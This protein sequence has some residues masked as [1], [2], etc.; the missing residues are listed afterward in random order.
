MIVTVI[1]PVLG[2]VV[3]AEGL[4]VIERSPHAVHE[5]PRRMVLNLIQDSMRRH[6]LR[7]V[8]TI[9]GA[10]HQESLCFH[11]LNKRLCVAQRLCRHVAVDVVAGNVLRPKLPIFD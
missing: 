1:N 5:P 6:D 7:D 10:M 4:D 8:V 2:T 9:F 3:P 11:L